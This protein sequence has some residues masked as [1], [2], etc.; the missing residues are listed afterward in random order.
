[1]YTDVSKLKYMQTIILDLQ[2]P[3]REMAPLTKHRGL[4][5]GLWHQADLGPRLG[6]T[7]CGLCDPSKLLCISKI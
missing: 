2:L 7:T 6:F 5:L 3:H 1:M 4:K